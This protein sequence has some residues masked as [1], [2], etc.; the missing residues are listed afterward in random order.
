LWAI[1]PTCR[2]VTYFKKAVSQRVEDQRKKELAGG[3]TQWGLRDG[4]S[5]GQ[6]HEKKE[7]L[8][9]QGIHMKKKWERGREEEETQKRTGRG[10]GKKRAR[11]CGE[12]Q[13]E[14]EI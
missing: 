2:E 14:E 7:S 6:G 13:N 10:P 9:V 5:I 1:Q 4:E 8:R 12:D 11:E 3:G